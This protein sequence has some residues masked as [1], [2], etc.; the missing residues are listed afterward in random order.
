MNMGKSRGVGRTRERAAPPTPPTH[1][2]GKASERTTDLLHNPQFLVR[3]GP[4]GCMRCAFTCAVLLST[5]IMSLRWWMWMDVHCMRFPFPFLPRHQPCTPS[6]R[7]AV[8][9]CRILERVAGSTMHR[10]AMPHYA[11]QLGR[12]ADDRRPH[13]R[14][15]HKI[16]GDLCCRH[17]ALPLP[18]GPAS[19]VTCFI[20][21]LIEQKFLLSDFF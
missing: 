4:S 19:S 5:S 11:G 12:Q 18:R 9:L 16:P 13:A 20:I 2:G 8:C 10:D 6:G 7:P 3:T 21:S 15:A 1:Q 17:S 14:R